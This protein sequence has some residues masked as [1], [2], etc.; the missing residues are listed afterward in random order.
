M[1]GRRESSLGLAYQQIPS[2]W[3][4]YFKLNI[5]DSNRTIERIF[6]RD[7]ITKRKISIEG[8]ARRMCIPSLKEKEIFRCKIDPP[9]YTVTL[10]IRGA[11]IPWMVAFICN[12]RKLHRRPQIVAPTDSAWIESGIFAFFKI[13][14]RIRFPRLSR[15]PVVHLTSLSLD[16]GW[17]SSPY[18]IPHHEEGR[19]KRLIAPNFKL[20]VT[21]LE[22]RK[23]QWKEI[24]DMLNKTTLDGK[25]SESSYNTKVR[26]TFVRLI[27]EVL[28]MVAVSVA[29]RHS[30]AASLLSN[31]T[32]L[33]TSGWKE[34]KPTERKSRL[35][36]TP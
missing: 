4:V 16:P 32:L 20:C 13:Y 9:R 2:S 26:S 17:S 34:L 14:W 12:G 33:R 10:L 19:Q 8:F 30:P 22:N 7:V 28:I 11:P 31:L 5:W 29:S 15:D 27:L 24:H 23:C 36:A 35:S 1:A 21:N 6:Y 3:G 18:V 25:S